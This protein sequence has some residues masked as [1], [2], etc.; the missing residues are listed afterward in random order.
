MN[1]C[2]FASAIFVLFAAIISFAQNP[3]AV[4]PKP[5]TPLEQTL[6]AHDQQVAQAFMKKDVEFFRGAVTDDFV[7]VGTDGATFGKADL[8]ENMR[9]TNIQEYRPYA[10]S[11]IPV[12]D[13]AAIVT[14]DCVVRMMVYDE[15]SPR[16][17]H[18]SDLWVKQGSEWRLKF[19]QATPTR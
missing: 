1:R 2:C 18:I 15:T 12:G 19:Q 3:G 13:D 9:E 7:A 16:Y 8:L 11:V 10:I 17:Q 6:I 4:V 14:Y 5:L